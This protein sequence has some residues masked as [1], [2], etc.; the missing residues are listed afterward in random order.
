[1]VLRRKQSTDKGVTDYVEQIMLA[2]ITYQII[3]KNKEGVMDIF[4]SPGPNDM[5]ARCHK[6]AQSG[7]SK[8]NDEDKLS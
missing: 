1:M 7:A 8:W 2:N 4:V 3:R 6:V 5:A